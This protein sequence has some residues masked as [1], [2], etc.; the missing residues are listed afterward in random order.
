MLSVV[1][2]YKEPAINLCSVLQICFISLSLFLWAMA[3]QQQPQQQPQQQFNFLCLPEV[4][5]SQVY[6]YLSI[7][8]C[9]NLR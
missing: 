8:D 4:T 3:S 6:R 7:Q 2:L 5:A 9:Q 1:V